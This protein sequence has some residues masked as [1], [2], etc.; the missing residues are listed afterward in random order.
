M[1]DK[2]YDPSSFKGS[3]LE[4]NILDG[5]SFESEGGSSSGGSFS[6]PNPG[7]AR[8]S[9]TLP[10]TASPGTAPIEQI[11]RAFAQ[12]NTKLPDPPR[13]DPAPLPGEDG[14]AFIEWGA[15]SN[16][17]VEEPPEKPIEDAMADDLVQDPGDADAG[18]TWTT[19]KAQKQKKKDKPQ[20]QKPGIDSFDFMD[21]T[22]QKGKVYHPDDA[23]IWIEVIRYTSVR[24]RGPKGRI[25][26]LNIKYPPFLDP[27][28]S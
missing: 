8:K 25:L 4:N 21:A 24:F 13:P 5:T 10:Y 1:A 12:V 26:K 20:D 2:F 15:P 27:P 11:V 17:E 16:F 23:E 14:E 18:P 28:A 9:S 3:S 19:S 22:A 7:A 6:I